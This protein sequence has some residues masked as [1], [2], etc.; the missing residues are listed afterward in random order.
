MAIAMETSALGPK[1]EQEIEC[2][3]SYSKVEIYSQRGWSQRVWG[4]SLEREHQGTYL[5]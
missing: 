2:E 4:E 3:P 1:W 5:L